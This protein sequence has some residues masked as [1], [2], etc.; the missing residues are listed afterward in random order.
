MTNSAAAR[1]WVALTVTVAVAL[2]IVT[3]A[4][5]SP[6]AGP[7][8]PPAPEAPRPSDRFVALGDF[9]TGG[10]DEAAVAALVATRRPAFVVTTGDN[11]YEPATLD[12]A[13]GRFYAPFIGAYHGAHGAGSPT[14]RFFPAL[15]NHDQYRW[16]GHDGLAD[17]L[18]YF[19]LP[20]A[21]V[22]STRPSGTERYYDVRWGPVHL[23]VLDANGGDGPRSD[24][25]RWLRAGLQASTAP[26]Q[27]VVMHQS[28][29]SSNPVHGSTPSAQWPYERWGADL[30]LSGHDHDYE[31]IVRDDDGDNRSLTYVVTGLGG[32]APYPF[33]SA[34]PVPGSRARFDGDRGTLVVDACVTNLRATFATVGG[35][36]IDGFALGRATEPAASPPH[37]FTDVD[38]RLG[39]AVS[40]LADPAHAYLPG[41][42]TG[43]FRPDDPLTRGEAARWLYRLAGAPDVSGL[44]PLR[45]AD[46]PSTQ[47]DAV[48]WLT[49]DPDGDGPGRP[50]GAG[51]G[52]DRFAPDDDLDR[53]TA[54]RWLYRLA[55][56]PDVSSV[57]APGFGDV[58]AGTGAAVRWLTDPCPAPR[59]ATGFRDGTFRPAQGFT[60]GQFASVV[61]RTYAR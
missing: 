15:G 24:Q 19:T 17:Y 36:L 46:V 16:P 7:P 30:V 44:E 14:N 31:R 38:A 28:P 32:N 25:G 21:G 13:V 29:Y 12:E 40:W 48:R 42:R 45:F 2:G 34:A 49:A 54:A 51:V 58:P 22:V 39:D 35:R 43:R 4:S 37:A 52:G 53:G 41:P 57:P 3:S 9:G 6:S 47:A 56:A 59:R 18:D 33:G 10:R 26:W 5:A 8:P 1:A 23:F 60:R 27:V 20:G 50:V 55:G 61:Y 11:A